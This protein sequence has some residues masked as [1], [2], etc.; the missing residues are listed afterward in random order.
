MKTLSENENYSEE[1]SGLIWVWLAISFMIKS[2]TGDCSELL[3]PCFIVL[4]CFNISYIAIS[5]HFFMPKESPTVANLP[6]PSNLLYL[7]C[8]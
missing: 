6:C 4:F 1:D 3:Y 5:P 7:I 2:P 8:Y